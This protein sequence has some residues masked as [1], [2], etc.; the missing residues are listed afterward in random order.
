MACLTEARSSGDVVA[1]VAVAKGCAA[2][3]GAA[4]R[5]NVGGCGK[6]GAGTVA[7]GTAVPVAC[8]TSGGG[9]GFCAF[10]AASFG[11]AAVLPDLSAGRDRGKGVDPGAG[12]GGGAVAPARRLAAATRI[13]SRN[14]RT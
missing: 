14:P 10:G 13:M 2:R 12:A 7:T 9:A 1:V 5:G 6:A 11:G 8:G 4:V 3:N